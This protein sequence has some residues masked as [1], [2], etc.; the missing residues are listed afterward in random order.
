MGILEK[1]SA[2]DLEIKGVQLYTEGNRPLTRIEFEELLNSP[3][4]YTLAFLKARQ[5]KYSSS[6]QRVT[7]LLLKEI[8]NYLASSPTWKR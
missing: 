7:T 3:Y 1:A 4:L 2:L 8:Q 6:T 5:N